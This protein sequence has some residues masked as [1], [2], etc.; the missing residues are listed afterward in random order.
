MSYIVESSVKSQIKPFNSLNIEEIVS[1]K[2]KLVK[3]NIKELK[4]TEIPVK[5]EEIVEEK[6]V[7]SPKTRKKVGDK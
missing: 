5:E 6:E 2:E 3:E 1:K 7:K 4:A